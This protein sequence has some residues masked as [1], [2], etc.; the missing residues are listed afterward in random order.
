MPETSCLSSRSHASV[1]QHILA[2][3][4]SIATG[5]CVPSS[6]VTNTLRCLFSQSSKA[7]HRSM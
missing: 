3:T 6:D 2:I 4:G 1:Y 7:L 5:H